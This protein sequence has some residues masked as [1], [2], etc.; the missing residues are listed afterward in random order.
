M[1]KLC[2]ALNL[3]LL[4]VL[5]GGCKTS[6]NVS[7]EDINTRVNTFIERYIKDNSFSGNVFAA[8][9]GNAVAVGKQYK[10]TLN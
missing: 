8:K 6:R 5:F 7:S 1:K 3:I 2:F 9:N 10:K 4:I